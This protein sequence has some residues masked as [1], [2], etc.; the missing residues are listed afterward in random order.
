MKLQHSTH[1]MP[2]FVFVTSFSRRV[3]LAGLDRVSKSRAFRYA[4][5]W[6]RKCTMYSCVAWS[7]IHSQLSMIPTKWSGSRL[8]SG[9]SD[10]TWEGASESN[11]WRRVERE[12]HCKIKWAESSGAV[13]HSLQVWSPGAVPFI[14]RR[15]FKA[16]ASRP[17]QP[18]SILT[19]KLVLVVACRLYRVEDQWWEGLHGYLL[20]YFRIFFCAGHTLRMR[21]PSTMTVSFCMCEPRIY[22]E[23]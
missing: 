15:N 8:I 16:S 14:L 4:R 1:L 10:L 23:I 18:T 21:I 12:G 20:A 22:K 2:F 13:K 19:R 17:S 3:S 9:S 5:S 11:S 6:S 7:L